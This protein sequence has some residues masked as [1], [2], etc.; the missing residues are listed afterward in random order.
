MT[1]SLTLN[2]NFRYLKDL[3]D[4]SLEIY[5]CESMNF[6]NR[7]HNE[8]INYVTNL[9][10][11]GRR[12]RD[13]KIFI[14]KHQVCHY[15]PTK[16]ENFFP[17]LQ[18]IEV[19]SSGLKQLKR[20]NFASFA[21][22]AMAIFPNN[23]I[24]SLPGD[25][26][27]YNPL[28]T[29]LDFSQNRIKSIGLGFFDKL[30]QLKY[31]NFDDNECYEGASLLMDDVEAVRIELMHNCSS[32]PRPEKTRVATKA[33]AIKVIE[34]EAR[35]DELKREDVKKADKAKAEINKLQPK[36]PKEE[37]DHGKSHSSSMEISFNIAVICFHLHIFSTLFSEI[38]IK[39]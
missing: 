24:E 15:L 6:T 23:D 7:Q 3:D 17:S 11:F 26:F 31:L 38:N 16:I 36:I 8:P 21:R 1:H 20:E 34:F 4:N 10:E 18:E 35:K 2:C 37:P 19:D 12:D 30:H 33:D 29:H 22:L 27:A 25:L 14:I 39:F 32:I 9:H 28:L 5:A 13:V